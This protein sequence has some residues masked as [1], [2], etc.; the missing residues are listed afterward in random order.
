V[1]TVSL[2]DMP[3]F[4]RQHDQAHIAEIQEWKRF[5]GRDA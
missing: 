4:M 1:G 5:T 3:A 2:C